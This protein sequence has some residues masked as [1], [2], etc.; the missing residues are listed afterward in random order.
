MEKGNRTGNTPGSQRGRREDKKA[1]LRNDLG[2]KEWG[3]R[4]DLRSAVDPLT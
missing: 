1:A 2:R 4:M 3:E